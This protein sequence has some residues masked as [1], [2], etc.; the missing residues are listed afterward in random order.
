MNFS[1]GF[2]GK[3]LLVAL[4]DKAREQNATMLQLGSTL[5]AVPFYESRGFQKVE[6]VWWNYSLLPNAK[7][8]YRRA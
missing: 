6:N 4:E 1:K 2:V 5:N 3:A 8:V 7:A